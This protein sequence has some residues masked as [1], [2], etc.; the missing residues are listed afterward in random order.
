M[1]AHAARSAQMET[2]GI[3]KQF[4]VTAEHIVNTVIPMIK[5]A[6]ELEVWWDYTDTIFRYSTLSNVH[7][8]HL[9]LTGEIG[10]S[11]TKIT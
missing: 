10:V 1:T 11:L 2:S 4:M 8:Q 3:M 5:D 7:H 6:V 9:T